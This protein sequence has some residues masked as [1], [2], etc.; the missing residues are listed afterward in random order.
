M[1]GWRY[2][3]FTLSNWPLGYFNFELEISRQQAAFKRINA[4]K[5]IVTYPTKP[6]PFCFA[7]MVARFREFYSNEPIEARVEKLLKQIEKK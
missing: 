4:Q 3:K 7:I 2:S 6:T 5:I 1:L